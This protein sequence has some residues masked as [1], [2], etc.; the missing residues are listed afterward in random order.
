MYEDNCLEDL[1]CPELIDTEGY[2]PEDEELSWFGIRD[3][4]D[5]D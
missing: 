3:L 5:E 1:Y 4:E 2:N